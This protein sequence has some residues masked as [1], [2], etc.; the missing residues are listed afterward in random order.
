MQMTLQIVVVDI[1]TDANK[2]RWGSGVSDLIIASN[3]VAHHND[4]VEH[5]DDDNDQG[6][7][8]NGQAG[9]YVPRE[10]AP[11]ITSVVNPRP[12]PTFAQLRLHW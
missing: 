2:I 8:G 3:K 9:G 5:N 11:I 1:D 6:A 7:A 10:P 12:P 4:H